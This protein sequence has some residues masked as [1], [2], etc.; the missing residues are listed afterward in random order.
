MTTYLFSKTA[1]RDLFTD[2][3]TTNAQDEKRVGQA[4][5]NYL[6]S[7]A[8]NVEKLA[9]QY[10]RTNA[11][12]TVS[13]RAAD[14]ETC[15]KIVLCC[16]NILGVESVNDQQEIADDEGGVADWYTVKSGDTLADIAQIYYQDA[17]KN[18]LIF[19]A[20]VPFLEHPDRIYPGQKLRIPPPPRKCVETE[21]VYRKNRLTDR[22]RL[23]K[24]PAE[25]K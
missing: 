19:A 20:N 14:R 1:G 23:N 6:N 5:L 15:E 4:I 9:I 18:M 25:T 3:D 12:V 7:L 17:Q 13:G 16:G 11:S 24:E 8:F 10:D 21:I 2:G 22:T